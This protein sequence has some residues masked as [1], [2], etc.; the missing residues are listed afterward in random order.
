[1]PLAWL[2]FNQIIM[3]KIVNA[4]HRLR[5]AIGQTDVS[6]NIV[7]ESGFIESLV[8]VPRLNKNFNAS[9]RATGM[10]YLGLKTSNQDQIIPKMP[11]DLFLQRG[12]KYIES[13]KPL[14]MQSN[15]GSY[16]LTLN[17]EVQ[18]TGDD[19]NDV[20]LDVIFNYDTKVK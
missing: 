14:N 5:P 10:I 3:K 4:I 13:F 6:Q 15:G 2:F 17:T 9:G 16:V 20:E 1:M 12:G 18:S 19:T 8:V 11:I 7:L